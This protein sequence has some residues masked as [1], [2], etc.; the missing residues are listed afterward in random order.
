MRACLQ[1]SLQQRL[2]VGIGGIH[3]HGA[4]RSKAARTP[5][6]ASAPRGRS[7]SA[8]GV[9][10]PSPGQRSVALRKQAPE[11]ALRR[12]GALGSVSGLTNPQE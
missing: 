11:F 3:R 9:A 7:R 1:R 12:P 4:R 6:D 5:A 2:V 8:S 10:G